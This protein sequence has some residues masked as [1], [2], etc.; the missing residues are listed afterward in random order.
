MW[1]SGTAG[2]VANSH[3]QRPWFNPEFRLLSV[4]S[5]IC[6]PHVPVGFIWDSQFLPNVQKHVDRQIDYKLSLDVKEWMH[7]ALS[8]AGDLPCAF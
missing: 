8:W 5:L 7:G 1:Q 3:L 4:C 2:N 6:C